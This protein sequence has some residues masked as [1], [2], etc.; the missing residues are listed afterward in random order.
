[1]SRLVYYYIE[2]DIIFLSGHLD[3][4]FFYLSGDVYWS[5]VII[6]GEV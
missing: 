4:S 1:M 3:A 2:K 5:K 6:L